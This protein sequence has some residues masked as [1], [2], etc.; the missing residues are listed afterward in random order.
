[1]SGDS[2]DSPI[3]SV[4]I[5]R[6]LH[7]QTDASTPE[8]NMIAQNASSLLSPNQTSWKIQEEN[9]QLRRMLEETQRILHSERQSIQLLKKRQ[10]KDEV[11]IEPIV[12]IFIL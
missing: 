11:A 2:N 12:F 9:L 5:S 3:Q 1:M 8:M 6:K 4:K 10:D 7:V